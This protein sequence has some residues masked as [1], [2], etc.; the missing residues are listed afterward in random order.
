MD[1]AQILPFRGRKPAGAPV[2]PGSPAHPAPWRVE[3]GIIFDAQDRVVGSTV[4]PQTADWVVRMVNLTLQP[5][6]D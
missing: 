3:Q 6:A 1:S 5:D 4:Q 2:A